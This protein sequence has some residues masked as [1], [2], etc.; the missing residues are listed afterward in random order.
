MRR[1]KRRPGERGQRSRVVRFRLRRIARVSSNV[2]ICKRIPQATYI[3]QHGP[4]NKPTPTRSP[5]TPHE[6]ITCSSPTR[7]FIAHQIPQPQTL[8]ATRDH[9]PHHLPRR[10]RTA[11]LQLPTQLCRVEPYRAGRVR[12]GCPCLV[13]EA[14][15][16]GAD[17]LA[18]AG[19]CEAVAAV[20]LGGGRVGRV[21][22]VVFEV[23][24][25]WVERDDG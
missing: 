14:A 6:S 23:G 15:G 25:G 9:L 20:G 3:R 5:P 16:G 12:V 10:P 21:V 7:P 22:V 8:G 2:H 4:L 11:P 1:F 17:A 24:V 19:P 13:P 18:A